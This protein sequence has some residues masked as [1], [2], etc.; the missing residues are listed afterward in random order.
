VPIWSP[1]FAGWTPDAFPSDIEAVKQD[2]LNNSGDGFQIYWEEFGTLNY[3]GNFIVI[4]DIESHPWFNADPSGS[5]LTQ[6]WGRGYNGAADVYS[7]ALI[8]DTAYSEKR[9][10]A[11]FSDRIMSGNKFSQHDD[12]F[13]LLTDPFN[14]T[15]HTS[16]LTTVR[17]Q[18]IDVYTSDIFIIDTVKI[19]YIRRPNEISLSLGV[20][21]ELP[22]HTHQEIVSM[23][24]SSILEE[25]SDPR[26]K[27]AVGEASRN[28]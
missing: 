10:P 1:T 18:A 17:G 13:T 24:V 6:A 7:P 16:P 12:I 19:T 14:S 8:M 21:C 28:E 15:K 25:I 9:V 27:T 4:V 26:Y 20:D 3:P 23:V 5:A 11:K 22:E 2:I